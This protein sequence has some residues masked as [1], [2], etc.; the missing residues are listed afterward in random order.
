MLTTR[1]LQRLVSGLLFFREDSNET[2]ALQLERRAARS[3]E[4]TFLL[5]GDDRYSYAQANRAINRHAHAYRKLGVGRGDVVALLMENRPAYLWHVFGLHKLG[6][7]VS[8]LNTNL[9]GEVLEHAI[10]ACE[11]SRIVVGS[12]L[13][14]RFA[15]IRQRLEQTIGAPAH[16]D[17]DPEEASA[18]A[19]IDAPTF[20]ALVAVAAD[21]DPD[22]TAQQR[23]DHLAAYIYTS[24]TTG[25]P[26][27]AVVKHERLFRAG[28]AWSGVLAYR[29]GDVMYNCL[30]LYHANGLLLAT[31]GVITGGVAMALGRRFSRRHFWDDVRK[32]GATHFIY[33]GE[34]C[35]YLMNN[36]PSA[37][38]RD[39]R[40]RA[41]T[42][43]GLRPEVWRD[44]QQRFG[45]PRIAEF[46]GA[47]EGNC[48]TLNFAN[49]VGSV[50]PLL[51]GMVLARWSEAHN[52]F[53]RDGR[54]FLIESKV[55]EPGI[56]LGKI[57]ARWRFEG[58]RDERESAGKVI[59]GAF[60]PGDA[61]F[62]TGDLLKRDWRRHL[63]FTDRVGDTFRW[64]G[65]NVSTT[66]V[67]EQ[68][69]K[70]PLAAE[71][72]AYGVQ[73]PGTEGRA[74][75]AAIVLADGARFDPA[76]FKA[77]VDR[78]L[79]AYARPLFVRL[80]RAL[81]TTSTFKLKKNDL[82]REGF[83][84]SASG[85]PIYLRH[86]ERGEYVAMSAPLYEQLA[87]G[88]LPL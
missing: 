54:G 60:A 51:P 59:R 72:N 43:N 74:G 34:L 26:K 49:V 40:V 29:S 57:S 35:R 39:H 56:L 73:V 44:F 70:W 62:N 22:T 55:G 76:A 45:I 82:Q 36:E 21:T 32:H 14:P 61:Y 68:I 8:L 16:V 19:S 12:E 52:D 28:A 63:F 9:A 25:R 24:G 83:Q 46:Y 71:V 27:A 7:V 47:T 30:P 53:V 58:Y 77:H 37:S 41:I 80:V 20:G 31:C 1:H 48:I 88:K 67:Q 6:A 23:L 2:L 4:R 3:P 81:E 64:K 87:S 85:D 84:P 75:M 42:G 15:E 50:G 38:D 17:V 65:E 13:W 5:Y 86:P 66:E 33:I 11:P 69:A 78:A 10:R 18:A 79:P